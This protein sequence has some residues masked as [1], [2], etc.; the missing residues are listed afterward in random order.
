MN[1]NSQNMAWQHGSS[2]SLIVNYYFNNKIEVPKKKEEEKVIMSQAVQHVCELWMKLM[3]IAYDGSRHSIFTPKK[4]NIKVLSLL[5]LKRQVCLVPEE[6]EMGAENFIF[7][8]Q[9]LNKMKI[10]L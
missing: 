6:L 8:W 7:E 3:N 5:I 2:S 1:R 9:T 10:T 4:S